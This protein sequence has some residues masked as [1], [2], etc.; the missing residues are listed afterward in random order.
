MKFTPE[1]QAALQTLK[2]NAESDFERHRIAVLE[3]DL[4]EPPK[5]EIIDDTHQKFDGVIY[6]KDKHGHFNKGIS[7]HRAVWRYY[8]GEI[9]PS[10]KQVCCSHSCGTKLWRQKQ[11]ASTTTSPDATTSPLN[12]SAD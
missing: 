2:D 11:K 3:K 9:V 8:N 6:Y 5:V 4:T 1:V 12:H 7:I 10:S